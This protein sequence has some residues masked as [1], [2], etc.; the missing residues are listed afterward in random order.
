MPRGNVLVI[1]TNR[2][3]NPLPQL[4]PLSLPLPS[5]KAEAFVL[6]GRRTACTNIDLN[7]QANCALPTGAELPE[8]SVAQIVGT[9]NNL[10]S[11]ENTQRVKNTF[12]AGLVCVCVCVRSSE[13]CML[14]L[15][16]PSCVC[17]CV[18]MRTRARSPGCA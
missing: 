17:V 2:A 11:G 7:N 8:W 5:Q 13:M 6:I 18:R 15:R 10:G 4:F 3:G 9:N 12:G 14:Y 16:S 1:C